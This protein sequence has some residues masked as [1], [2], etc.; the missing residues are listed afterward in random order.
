MH[1]RI[2]TIKHN[3]ESLDDIISYLETVESDVQSIDG[4]QS[5]TVVNISDTE[6]IAFSAYENEDQMNNAAEKYREI[7]GGMAQHITAPPEM[8]NGD[9]IWTW[10]R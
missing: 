2:T 7:M 4:L 5:V 6:S 10:V 1:Y 9:S 3:S 8:S